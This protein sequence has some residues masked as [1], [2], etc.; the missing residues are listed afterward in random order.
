VSECSNPALMSPA[1]V[2][3]PV[4]ATVIISSKIDSPALTLSPPAVISIPATSIPPEK[5]E[6]AVPRTVRVLVAIMSPVLR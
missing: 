1:N 5:V 3:V 6:V 4:S 2:D